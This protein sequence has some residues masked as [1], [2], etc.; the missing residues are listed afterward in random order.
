[1]E[2]GGTRG[3]MVEWDMEVGYQT[4]NG[5]SVRVGFQTK[6]GVPDMNGVPDRDGVPVI[7]WDAKTCGVS[8]RDG[9]VPDRDG[10]IPDR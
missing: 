6:D 3:N 8:D 5:V 10:G 1:M 4:G 9:E 7:G 2:A